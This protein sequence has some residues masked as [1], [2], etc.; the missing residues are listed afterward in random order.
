VCHV[1]SVLTGW[2]QELYT[3]Q[4]DSSIITAE[5]TG[6]LLKLL[7]DAVQASTAAAAAASPRSLLSSVS[8]T[9]TSASSVQQHLQLLSA[10]QSKV[11]AGPSSSSTAVDLQPFITAAG[12]VLSYLRYQQSQALLPLLRDFSR[13]GRKGLALFSADPMLLRIEVQQLLQPASLQQ[14][15]LDAARSRVGATQQLPAGS[16]VLPWEVG[17]TTVAAAWVKHVKILCHQCPLQPT[18]ILT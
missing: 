1:L 9:P 12:D 4:S 13:S 11:V 14:W 5:H 6:A 16:Q 15:Y 17:P 8:T 3:H 2:L 18:N 10:Y 7:Q